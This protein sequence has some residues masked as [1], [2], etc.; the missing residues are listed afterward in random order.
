MPDF[1]TEP[2]GLLEVNCYL[3]PAGQTLYIIDPGADAEIIVR[4]ARQFDC[5]ER[6]ILLTHAHI[7]HIGAVGA[8]ARALN[9]RTVYLHKRDVELYFSPAN[10]LPPWL[11]PVQDLPQPDSDFV[12]EDFEIIE[13][14]GHTQ[15]GVCFYFRDRERP[16][17]FAG[18]TIFAGS[19]GRTDLPGGDHRQLIESIRGKLLPLPDELT[20]YPGHGRP[21]TIGQEKTANPY[22]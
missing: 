18:D 6:V 8:V 4:R 3:I 11:P 7:D 1:I 12:S 9:I 19:V 20:V 22:L 14:P 21:T 2:V 16:V 15:G 10:A 13:T 17:L 5:A